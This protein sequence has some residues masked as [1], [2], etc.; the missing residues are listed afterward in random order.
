MTAMV[1]AAM[2]V[3]LIGGGGIGKTINKE[4]SGNGMMA[5]RK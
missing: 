3:V 2:V 5:G 4:D 1:A